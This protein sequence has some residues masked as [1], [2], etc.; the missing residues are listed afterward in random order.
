MKI[1]LSTMVNFYDIEVVEKEKRMVFK[2]FAANI[3]GTKFYVK[4]KQN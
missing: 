1:I 2:E 4:A 3:E